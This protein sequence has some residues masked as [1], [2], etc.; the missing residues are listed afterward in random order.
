ME[1]AMTEEQER[2]TTRKVATIV[3]TN[4]N[5]NGFIPILYLIFFGISTPESTTI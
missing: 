2:E 1:R 5:F 4:F 3:D